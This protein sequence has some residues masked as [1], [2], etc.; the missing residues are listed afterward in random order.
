MLIKTK[1]L[2]MNT[3]LAFKLSYAVFFML[4]STDLLVSG[5]SFRNN[6]LVKK[7]YFKKTKKFESPIV[8]QICNNFKK[9]RAFYD[10]SMKLGTC[11]VDSNTK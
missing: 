9:N 10:K 4:N 1:M 7:L 2:T 6:R 8:G 3:F 5:K 11:L